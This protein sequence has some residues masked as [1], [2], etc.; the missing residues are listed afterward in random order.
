MSK[1]NFDKLGASASTICL[2]HCTILPLFISAFP[3]FALKIASFEIM[4]V[5]LFISAIIFGGAAVCYGYKKHSI[6][7]PSLF[8]SFG[9][10]CLLLGRI[11]D[12]SHYFMYHIII[13]ILAGSSL[14]AGHFINNKLCHMCNK[15]SDT[16]CIK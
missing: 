15:C 16:K 11:T 10:F 1:I 9:I 6:V 5:I 13:M 3:L 4:E 12:N 14:V 7:T 2:I 8:I